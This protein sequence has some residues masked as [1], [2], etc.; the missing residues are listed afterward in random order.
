M[1]NEATVTSG[2]TIQKRSSAGVT[3]IDYVSRPG[4]FRA[5]VTGTKGPTPGAITAPRFGKVVR[6]EELTEPG[7]V[8]FKNLDASNAVE[9]GLY[10]VGLDK[11][12]PF[13]E[14]LAGEGFAWRFSRNFREA[15]LGTGTGTGSL[16]GMQF[17]VMGLGADV[18][19]TVEAFER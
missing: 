16:G 14:A 17:Y 13:G 1:A 12:Y 9:Y 3:L 18:N 5:D 8:W 6:F 15:Y 11:F 19:C 2:L 10:D 7:L 4:A